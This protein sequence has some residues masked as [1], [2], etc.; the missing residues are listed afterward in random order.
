MPIKKPMLAVN[1]KSMDKIP[2][3]VGATPK[4]DGFRTLRLKRGTVTRKFLPHPNKYIRKILDDVALEGMDGETIVEGQ[5]FHKV[6]SLI[7]RE[8]GEPDF[9][10]MVFD[11]VIDPKEP[12]H[13]RMMRMSR[14]PPMPHIKF[15]VPKIIRNV[16][17]MKAYEQECIDL[18]YE[19]VIVRTLD[20]P[21]KFGRS[22]LN[23]GWMLKIKRFED[24]EAKILGFYE[25]MHN[26]NEAEEDALGHTKRSSCAAG[27]VCADTLGGFYVKDL[28]TGVEFKLGSGELDATEQKKIW[29][30][31]EKYIGKIAKYKFQAY[32]TKDKPRIA[33]FVGF[34]EKWDM[35]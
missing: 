8:D 11:Y 21:Y 20:S 31:R 3:P 23:Q 10:F 2:Y 33:T 26:F 16:E 9:T 6:S 19:G 14:L 5:P 25:R 18:G 13:L 30:N 34:R 32:G 28:K 24:S 12:Y 7:S 17:E 27:K 1:I 4:V 29:D 35:D 15:L 22:T